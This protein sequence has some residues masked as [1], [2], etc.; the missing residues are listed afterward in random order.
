MQKDVGSV[1]ALYPT[2]VTIVGLVKDG[3]VNFLTVAHVGV[4]EHGHLLISIDKAHTF[5]DAGIKEHGVVS[6]SLVNRELLTA[7]DYCGMH[8]GAQ[9][10]K[11][12]VFRY[13]F[14]ELAYAP[15]LDDAPV[16]MECRIVDSME[17]GNFTNYIL[18]PV[19]TF[20]QEECLNE[21]GRVDYEKVAPVLFEFQNGQ[22][23]STG[24]VIGK[25]WSEGKNY[26]PKK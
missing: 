10:D 14:G 13:H 6:V 4:V 8:K 23:L 1:M 9:E 21:R 11:S 17:V 20:V 5:S 7:A 24:K 26:T 3:Q 25:C 19:H 12:G 22:Y 2:P 18:K 15:I 16:S